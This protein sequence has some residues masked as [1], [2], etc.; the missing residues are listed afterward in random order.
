MSN[1]RDQLE[2]AYRATDYRVEDI[3]GGPLVICIDE[4]CDQLP[5]AEWAFVTACNPRSVCL[6]EED[7]ARRTAELEA[8]VGELGRIYFHGHGVGRNGTWPPEPSLLILGI[9]E[10]DAVELA[11]RFGQNAIVAGRPGEPARLV[12]VG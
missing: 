12:W 9:A 3:P 7:N 2:A 1:P 6:S 11:K 5:A 8:A 4:R 10:P